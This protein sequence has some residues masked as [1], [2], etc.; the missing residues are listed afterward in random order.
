MRRLSTLLIVMAMTGL[1]PAG[2]SAHAGEIVELSAITD[3]FVS[4]ANPG[5]NYGGAG[6]LSVSA[7]GLPRGEFQSVLRF[8]SA[9]A[10]ALL[11]AQFGAG[12]WSIQTV[13]LRLTTT[14]PNNPIFNALSDGNVVVRWLQNDGWIEGS[15]TPNIP[16]TSGITF[17]TLPGILTPSDQ[18]LGSFS[19]SGEVT[20]PAS[21]LLTPAGPFIADL[22]AGS[23]VS[24]HLLPGDTSVGMLVHSRNFGD[25]VA[26]PRLIL[27]VVPEPGSLGLILSL[28]A[29]ATSR[30][31]RGADR[32]IAFDQSHR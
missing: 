6:G 19:F 2:G 26:H 25:P 8:N 23:D 11:D 10:T 17:G 22:A 21:Y 14:T 27:T 31:R 12:Q 30:R 4:G 32:V 29:L 1:P 13:H 20:G 16:D 5:N 18:P 7:A 24:L 15:G 28:L 9:A 3:A